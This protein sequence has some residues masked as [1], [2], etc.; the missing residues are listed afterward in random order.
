MGIFVIHYLTTIVSKQLTAIAGRFATETHSKLMMKSKCCFNV[1]IW[2]IECLAKLPQ[3]K[4][5]TALTSKVSVY[6]GVIRMTTWGCLWK[7][8]VSNQARGEMFID[9]FQTK[10]APKRSTC[11]ANNHQSSYLKWSV[12]DSSKIWFSAKSATV[13]FGQKTLWKKTFVKTINQDIFRHNNCPHEFL[14]YIPGSQVS[15]TLPQQE[16]LTAFRS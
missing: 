14:H 6:F 10:T 3:Q 16:A 1:Q 9:V 7:D 13:G 2:K 15:A 4:A 12:S 8:C 11:E 5:L